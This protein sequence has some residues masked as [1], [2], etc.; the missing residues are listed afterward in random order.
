MCSVAVALVT[1]RHA[2]VPTAALAGGRLGRWWSR[3]S[4]SGGRSAVPQSASPWQE[5][6]P[7]KGWPPYH[8]AWQPG[9]ALGCRRRRRRPQVRQARGRAVWTNRA[10]RTTRRSTPPRGPRQRVFRPGTSERGGRSNGRLPG[11]LR[12]PPSSEPHGGAHPSSRLA[13]TTLPSRPDEEPSAAAC[14][15]PRSTRRRPIA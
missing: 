3:R 2:P 8:P 4:V 14:M 7:A 11:A 5:R 1:P 6:G 15:H 13:P 12:R 10:K 9:Q